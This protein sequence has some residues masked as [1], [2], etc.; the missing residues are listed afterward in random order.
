MMK[1]LFA[2]MVMAGLSISLVGCAEKAPAPAPDS[3]PAVVTPA[4]GAKPAGE[5]APAEA[6]PA[7]GDKK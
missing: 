3:P 6:A 5:A 4:D 1:K 7:E 2:G